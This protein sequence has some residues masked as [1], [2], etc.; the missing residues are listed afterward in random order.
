MANLQL[1]PGPVNVEKRAALPRDWLYKHFSEP[2]QRDQWLL[3]YD[4]SSLPGSLAGFMNFAD[5]RR[6]RMGRRLA[7]LLGSVPGRTSGEGIEAGEPAGAIDE[8]AE[9]I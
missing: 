8:E 6:H 5:A 7:Q 2:E 1:L 9:M 4:I 3:T